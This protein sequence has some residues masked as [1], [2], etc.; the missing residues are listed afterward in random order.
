MRTTSTRALVALSLIAALKLAVAARW[1]L[2]ADE[3]YHY[4]WSLRPALGYYDQPPLIAWVLAAERWFGASP[5]VLRAIPALGWVAAIGALTPFA[6][7]RAAWWLW[8]AALPPLFLLTN[9][10]VP[11]A[12]LLAC[13]GIGLAGALRGGRGWLVA[14]AFGGLASLAKYSGAALVPLLILAAPAAERRERWP[15]IGLA[16]AVACLLPNGWWNA[17]HHGVTLGFVLAEGLATHPR[18]GWSG[19]VVEVRDQIAFATPIAWGLAVWSAVRAVGGGDR[20]D[21]L[22]SASCLPLWIGFAAAAYGGRPEAHWPAP[23]WIGAGLLVSRL[24]AGRWRA[25]AVGT[26]AAATLAILVHAERPLVALAVDPAVRLE[27]GAALADL[28]HRPLA[29]LFTER[30]QEASLLAY[31]SQGPASVLPG[32]G[33]RSQY[34]LWDEPVPPR[35]LFLRPATTGG[36]PRCLLARCASVTEGTV[37]RATDRH[38]RTVG[39]WDLFAA[40]GC[41]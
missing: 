23:A 5:V 8:A 13:W 35:L 21:R 17:T 31:Y 22:L 11:D 33:R 16:L 19:V 20:V 40:E 4:A 41:Q 1:G 36:R 30:Y 24:P 27:E 28:V 10:A 37:L 14:G 32:C 2:L 7:D 15:W 38:G 18:P 29:P 34:D 6:R 12:L 39:A 9:L 25:W 3:A 26:A